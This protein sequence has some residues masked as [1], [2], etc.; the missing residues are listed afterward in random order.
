MTGFQPHPGLP[1]DA[2]GNQVPAIDVARVCE[3][4]GAAVRVCDPF[5]VEETQRVLFD[6][7]ENKDGVSVLVLRR[8]CALSPEKKAKKDYSMAVDGVVC[9]G[10]NCGCNRFCTR[11]FKCPGLIWDKEKNVAKIDEVI[12][13]GCG[14]CASI[15]PSGAIRKTEAA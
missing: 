15:C 11:I 13:T 6:L 10:E 9:L 5:D 8:I 3:A 2:A 7:L 1:V 12:C 14:V 4:I